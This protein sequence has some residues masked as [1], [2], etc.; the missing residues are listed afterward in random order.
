MKHKKIAR[1]P[2]PV[3][4]SDDQGYV[5]IYCDSTAHEGTIWGV[6]TYTVLSSG[7]FRASQYYV[8]TDG[9]THLGQFK[10]QPIT[11]AEDDSTEGWG[12]RN[13]EHLECHLCGR[14]GSVD[15]RAE[16]F[17]PILAKAYAAG[18]SSLSLSALAAI[19]TTN[20]RLQ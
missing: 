11:L 12:H 18:V 7:D 9:S 3:V 17:A 16:R 8:E 19:V 2:S 1:D 13:V 20:R 4:L 14:P 6:R 15:I 5:S 10:E